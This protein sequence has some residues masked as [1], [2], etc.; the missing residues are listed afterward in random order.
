MAPRSAVV[1]QHKG[2][3]IYINNEEML[4]SVVVALGLAPCIP[5]RHCHAAADIEMYEIFSDKSV[6]YAEQGVQCE[7]LPLML[8][9]QVQVDAGP[10][11]ERVPDAAQERPLA[12]DQC[13][14][15][16]QTD[17]VSCDHVVSASS[18]QTEVTGIDKCVG[19]DLLL[20]PLA[21]YGSGVVDTA[22][23]SVGTCEPVFTQTDVLSLMDKKVAVINDQFRT[24]NDALD[25]CRADLVSVTQVRDDLVSQLDAIRLQVGSDLAVHRSRSVKKKSK[26]R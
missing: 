3:T 1:I 17:E 24:A 10:A 26:H 8:D 23:I 7:A 16:T 20:L 5:A 12:V 6:E 14:A 13:V 25:Q 9:A 11:L 21:R 2:A 18:T 4:K 19:S 22:D 15:C